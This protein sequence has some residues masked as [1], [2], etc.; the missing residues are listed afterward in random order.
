[1]ATL[2]TIRTRIASVKNTQK[3]TKA[4]KMVSAAK[5]RR[6]QLRLIQARPYSEKMKSLLGQMV[7]LI[8]G[9]PHP[10]F[11]KREKVRSAEF[12]IFTSD[13][14]LCGGFNGN[15]LRRIENFLKEK[16]KECEDV[17]IR[18]IGKKGRDFFRSRKRE[19]DQLVTGI[20]ENFPFDQALTMA[21]EL[22]RNYQEG[23]FDEFYLVYNFFRSAISQEVQIQRLLPLEV[24]TVTSEG[25]LPEY[26]YEPKRPQLLENLIPRALAT[27]IRQSFLESVAGEYGARMVAM[28]NATNN[29]K[30]MIYDLTL[31]MNRLRQAAITKELMDIVNGSEALK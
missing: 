22:I 24:P 26:L 20:P 1:M 28:D 9:I 8:D 3:I 21:N 2:K 4:M 10:V 15:L 12:L 19:P 29:S 25:Y 5:L 7:R 16:K 18:V 14:G 13:R 23:K 17:K 31:E 30:E 11:E 6:A 27:I